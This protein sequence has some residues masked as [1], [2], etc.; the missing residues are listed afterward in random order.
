MDKLVIQGG[1]PLDG[2][3]TVSGS[4]NAALPILMATLLAKEPVSISNVPHLQDVTTSIALLGRLGIKITVDERMNVLVDSSNISSFEA[5]YDLVKTMRASILVLGPMLARYGKAKVSLPGGC[6][7]GSRPVDLHIKAM[8]ALGADVDV[9]NGYICATHKGRLKGTNIV[10][11]T[12]TVTGTEN[13]VMAAVL[14]KG[15]TTIE[16]AAREPEVADL[17]HFLVSLG[18]KIEGIG[19]QSITIHGVEALSGG[20]YSVMP[21]RIEA[22]TYLAAACVTRGRVKV[23]K[24]SPDV[25]TSVLQKF[26]EAGAHVTTGEDWIEVDMKSKRSKAVNLCT[27]PYPGFP[28]DMQAQFMAINV[29]ADGTGAIT[30]TIFENRFMHASEMERMG[31]IIKLSGNTAICTGVEKVQGTQVMATDLRASASLILLGLAAEGETSVDRIYH[32]DR[33][34]ECIE[35]KLTQL[36]ADIVRVP[37]RRLAVGQ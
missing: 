13:A 5:P 31:A 18:A 15:T 17:C 34:Y 10:F 37:S 2:E 28:T 21:D 36:G 26:Q 23:K 16:N 33:G 11:D 14:A 22:G 1:K 12:V 29:I 20:S 7:I 3:I 24:I 25:M 35:E 32:V 19:T 8:Q 9:K 27:N 4:K 30:E 6:A